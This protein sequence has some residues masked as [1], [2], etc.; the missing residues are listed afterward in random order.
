[1]VNRELPLYIKKG[2]H[3]IFS[4]RIIPTELSINNRK[5][6]E[7]GL[8]KIGARIFRDIHVSGHAS[9]EDDRDLLE[10]VNP[11]HVIPAHADDEKKS[12][13]I[14]LAKEAGKKAHLMKNGQRLKLS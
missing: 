12:G 10:L 4:C 2:D 5:I 7:D 6:L 9:G 3:I 11:K 13:L 1:M 8:K 14:E